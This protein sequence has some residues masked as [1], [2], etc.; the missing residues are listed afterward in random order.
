MS[1]T[2]VGAALVWV[3]E[4]RIGLIDFLEPLLSVCCFVYIRVELPR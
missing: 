3:R 1:K 4:H 2:I